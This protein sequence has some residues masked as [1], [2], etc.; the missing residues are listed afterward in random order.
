M[1]IILNYPERE[2][3]SLHR[4]CSTKV[5]VRWTRRVMVVFHV[6][7]RETLSFVNVSWGECD[8]DWVC[9]TIL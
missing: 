4:V 3:L 7:I 2:G 1:F 6:N 9:H 5:K 8:K